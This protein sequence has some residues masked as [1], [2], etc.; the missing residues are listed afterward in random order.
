MRLSAAMVQ[1]LAEELARQRRRA[2]AKEEDRV[3][4]AAR[5]QGVLPDQV[6][7]GEDEVRHQIV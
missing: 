1:E 3:H 7:F 6:A 2:V 5:A 4:D